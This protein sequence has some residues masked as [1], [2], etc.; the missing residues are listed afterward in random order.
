MD[1]KSPEPQFDK[2][3]PILA[4]PPEPKLWFTDVKAGIVAG[5]PIILLMV[6]LVVNSSY[7]IEFFLPKNQPLGLS[8]LI[9]VLMLSVIAYLILRFGSQQLDKFT[10]QTTRSHLI[11]QAVRIGF[12]VSVLL[13][14]VMPATWIVLLGPVGLLLRNSAL[15]GILF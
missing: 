12:H 7:V 15:S 8:M 14:L 13:F 5:L 3:P 9:V 10:T 11:R 2:E 6:L 4:L 1:M